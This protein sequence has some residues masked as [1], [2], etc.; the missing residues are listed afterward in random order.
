MQ[1]LVHGQ[2]REKQLRSD[3]RQQR[4]AKAAAQTVETKGPASIQPSSI[5]LDIS[6]GLTAKTVDDAYSFHLGGRV[7]VD[8]GASS[9]PE[10]GLGSTANVTQ[11]RLQVEGKIA[12]IFDYR[13]QYDFAGSNTSTVGAA[14]GI[15]DAYV[16]VRHPA[17]Q[18]PI[19]SAPLAIQ[20][21]NFWEP[22]GLERT[23]SKNYTDFVERSLMSDVFGSNRHIGVALLAADSNWS[24][25][26]GVF[27]TSVEDKTLTP[28]VDVGVPSW[29]SSKAGWVAT[30]GRQYF[31]VAGRVTYQ[32]ILERDKLF[33]L[34]LSGR[35]H[36]PNDATGANDDRVMLLGANTAAESNLLKENLL[37][38]PDLSCGSVALAGNPAVAGKCVRDVV[39]FG[40]EMAAAFG[41]FS[42]QA[43]YMRA[44]YDRDPGAILTA[45]AA[46]LYAPG[47]KSLD[48]DGYYVYGVWTLTGESRAAAFQTNNLSP[49]SFRQA[50]I[51]KPLSKGGIGAWDL[52]VRWSAVNLNNGP[53]AGSTF[54]NLLAASPNAAS[55][56]V[57]ANSSVLGGQEQ[58]VT[59]GLNWRPEVGVRLM[60]NYTRVTRLVA[61][62]DRAYLNGAHPSTFLL[63]TQVDW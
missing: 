63:R 47:G 22:M 54:A 42:V 48:F 16:A 55:R 33:H 40:A 59:V 24:A 12:S 5:V 6:H 39:T 51:D 56:S 29:V 58:D 31:D 27:S 50:P 1:H 4:A 36:Q 30:G 44:H 7:H 3:E 13:F 35:Y 41:P 17:L 52:A 9:A 49:A 23:T 28:S 43:E 15:R 10:R 37:G 25:K 11:A 57:I 20:V 53:Y 60:A 21:G 14:G 61:P 46:G 2:H 18:L 62:W 19:G 38:T 34:G 26:V 45:N 32:P 8:G